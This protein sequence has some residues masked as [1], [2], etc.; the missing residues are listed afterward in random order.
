MGYELSI[1]MLFPCYNT[2]AAGGACDRL[3]FVRIPQE[4]ASGNG[5]GYKLRGQ[6]QTPQRSGVHRIESGI[7]GR[8]YQLFFPDVGHCI[9]VGG[10]E[11][12]PGFFPDVGHFIVVG[13]GVPE[14]G[15]H[16]RSRK[17]ATPL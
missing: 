8:V 9:V 6:T 10:G 16:M 7:G 1:G 14:M 4:L 2:A 13:E 5:E 12:V 11:S 3:A 17:N 15:L